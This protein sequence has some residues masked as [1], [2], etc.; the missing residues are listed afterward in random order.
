MLEFSCENSETDRWSLAVGLT[1]HAYVDNLLSWMRVPP[2]NDSSVYLFH[3]FFLFLSPFS[4]GCFI[5]QVMGV[6]LV[7][8]SKARPRGGA[9]GSRLMYSRQ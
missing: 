8:P 5:E 2:V 6:S 1:W 7:A 4:H 9:L 3:L